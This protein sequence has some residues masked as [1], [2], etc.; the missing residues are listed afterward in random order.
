[1]RNRFN[2]GESVMQVAMNPPG[3]N[4]ISTT[5][6]AVQYSTVVSNVLTALTFGESVELHR[7]YQQSITADFTGTGG[8]VPTVRDWVAIDSAVHKLGVTPEQADYM[9]GNVQ[10][11]ILEL[12]F[13]TSGGK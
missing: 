7:L 4:S 5:G 8:G 13:A 11:G 3:P 9:E 6:A 12:V 2:N 10:R 1:M